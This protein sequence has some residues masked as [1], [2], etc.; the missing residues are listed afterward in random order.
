VGCRL[1][2]RKAE[3]DSLC[4]YHFDARDE[5]KKGYERWRDAYSSMSWREYLDRIKRLD[6]TGQWVKEVADLME[7]E[8]ID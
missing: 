7:R 1:C 5:L 2:R 4:R 8:D 6:G 3:I